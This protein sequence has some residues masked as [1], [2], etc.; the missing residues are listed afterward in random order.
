MIIKY[1]CAH[2]IETKTALE[3]DVDSLISAFD[4]IFIETEKLGFSKKSLL[5]LTP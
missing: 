1:M 2:I 5:N 3:S 4:K